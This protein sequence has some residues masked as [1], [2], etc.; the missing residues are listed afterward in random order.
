M[1]QGPEERSDA[2]DLARTESSPK[3]RAGPRGAGL[4]LVAVLLCTL[5]AAGYAL[6]HLLQAARR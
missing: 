1:T 3:E 2:P 5:A 6:L 4:T